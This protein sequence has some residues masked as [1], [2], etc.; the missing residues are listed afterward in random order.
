MLH[1]K[2]VIAPQTICLTVSLL[3]PSNP[4]QFPTKEFGK[5]KFNLLMYYFIILKGELIDHIFNRDGV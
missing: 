2:I 4:A 5:L 1:Q 3:L